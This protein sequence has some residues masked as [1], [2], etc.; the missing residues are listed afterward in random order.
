V[1]AEAEARLHAESEQRFI[2]AESDLLEL[3]QVPLTAFF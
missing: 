1:Q 3:K 2:E